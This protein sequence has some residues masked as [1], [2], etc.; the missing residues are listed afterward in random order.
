LF[1]YRPDLVHLSQS[2]LDLAQKAKEDLE[3]LQ[4]KQRAWRAKKKI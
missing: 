2:N 1:R 4:R 3:N